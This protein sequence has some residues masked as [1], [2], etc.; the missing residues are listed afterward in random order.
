MSLIEDA[1]NKQGTLTDASENTLHAQGLDELSEKSWG[2]IAV[3][4]DEIC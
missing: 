3:Q 2:G 1:E 4:G